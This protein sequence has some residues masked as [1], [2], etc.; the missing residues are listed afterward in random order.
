MRADQRKFHYI[1][2]ITREDGKFYIGMHS[3]DNLEDGYFGSGVL[4][5]KSIKKHGKEKHTKEI[6]EFLP[7]RASLRTRERTL[8]NEEILDDPLCMNLC[9][10]GEGGF[11][12]LNSKR[13]NLYGKNGTIGYGGENLVA[14]RSA[15]AAKNRWEMHYDTLVKSSR[16]NICAAQCASNSDS[17]KQ[18][19]AITFVNTKHQQG[20]K[21]S[22]YG[23]CWVNDGHKA[24][25]IKRCE[26]EDYI[27]K[28]YKLGRS[29]NK[30]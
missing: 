6:L 23:T 2:K 12:T 24:I 9:L 7:D 28:G 3:T 11:D 26:L 4:L 1:Y 20:V 19:R 25:K 27:F 5:W 22:Q 17:A 16:Q 8:V 15:E 29:T 13:Q 10:G 14:G 30:I 18:K 21:N